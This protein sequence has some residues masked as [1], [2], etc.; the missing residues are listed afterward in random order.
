[1]ETLTQRI[2]QVQSRRVIRVTT[3]LAGMRK[4][5]DFVVYPFKLGETSIMIQSDKAIAKFDTVT[6]AG[7]INWRG[8]N[9]KY[10]VHLCEAL[11]A[12]PYQFTP[13]FVLECQAAQPGSGD[14]VGNNIYIA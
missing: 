13:E 1:M 9:S 4:A 14:M 12:E 3:K 7:V 10:G 6:G 5:Q 11:G 8:S 2:G